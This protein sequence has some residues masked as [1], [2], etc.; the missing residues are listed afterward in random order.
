MPSSRSANR[1][2]STVTQNNNV[3]P[4]P[5][6]HNGRRLS[7]TDTF[8]VKSFEEH[9][10][11]PVLPPLTKSREASE[12]DI[13]SRVQQ[14]ISGVSE[15][16]FQVMLREMRTADRDRD[17]VLRPEQIEAFMEKFKVPVQGVL[18]HLQQRFEDSTFEGMT[19]YEDL[20]KYFGKIR[21][22]TVKEPGSIQAAPELANVRD[23][24]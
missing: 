18:F 24:E 7:L 13:D 22:R 4:H 23:R 1:N 21:S 6:F 8:T 14:S 16:S 9:S 3:P 2:K 17:G 11:Y 5:N 10:R 19:N 12:E 20:L 15:R